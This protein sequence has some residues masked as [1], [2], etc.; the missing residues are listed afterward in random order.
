MIRNLLAVATLLTAL[1]PAWAV[2]FANGN[3]EEGAKS[4]D[5]HQCS[6]CHMQKFGG[7]GNKIYTRSDRKVNSP[8]TLATQIRACSTNLGLMMFED[9]EENISAFL[10]KHFYKFK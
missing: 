2:P 1:Q 3:I 8:Q 6:S 10:N 9:E 4:V 5:Q 7:D